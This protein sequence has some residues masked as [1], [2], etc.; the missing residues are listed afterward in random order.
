MQD[1]RLTIEG[2]PRLLTPAT[3]LDRLIPLCSAPPSPVSPPFVPSLSALPVSRT[4]PAVPGLSALP[5]AVLGRLLLALP[6]PPPT[7]VFRTDAGMPADV[8]GLG[9]TRDGGGMAFASRAAFVSLSR[10]F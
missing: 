6:T 7:A 9:R 1:S 4:L 5:I 3:V 10:A 8:V 2:A